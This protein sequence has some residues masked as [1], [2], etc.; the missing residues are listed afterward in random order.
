VAWAWAEAIWSA[1]SFW[2]EKNI[3]IATAIRIRATPSTKSLVKR[4]LVSRRVSAV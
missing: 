3:A 4:R 2:L 1:P